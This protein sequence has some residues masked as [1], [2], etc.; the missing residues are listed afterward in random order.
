MTLTEFLLARI[1]EDEGVARRASGALA[2]TQ[3]YPRKAWIESASGER[4]VEF[5]ERRLVA[6]DQATLALCEQMARWLPGRVLAE[7]EA[8]RRIMDLHNPCG[9]WTAGNP[10]EELCALAS[11][12]ADHPDFDPEWGA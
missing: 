8:K 9:H 2:F 4:V 11:P 5:D 10:C 7:C 6:A 1:A 12:Y 3:D